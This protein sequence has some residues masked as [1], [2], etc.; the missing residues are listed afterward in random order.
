MLSSRS[1]NFQESNRRILTHAHTFVGMLFCDNVNLIS[2]SI[3]ISQATSAFFTQ[4]LAQSTTEFYS[5]YLS[6]SIP[7]CSNKWLCFHALIST[8]PDL[9]PFFS[10][11]FLIV[12]AHSFIKFA[13]LLHIFHAHSD[14]EQQGQTCQ[15]KCV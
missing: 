14:T 10:F 1:V 12:L 8:Q 13:F 2:I 9:F 15:V 7:Q 5:L 3:P 11:P 4:T 6:I